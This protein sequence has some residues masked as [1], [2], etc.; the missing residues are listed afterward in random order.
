MRTPPLPS[1]PLHSELRRRIDL[2]GPLL[3]LLGAIG[4]A[5]VGVACGEAHSSLRPAT[6]AASSGAAQP[7][8]GDPAA[9]ANPA[10]SPA[11]ATPPSAPPG[12]SAP[13]LAAGWQVFGHEL[14]GKLFESNLK[15][16]GAPPRC[17]TFDY[18]PDGGIQS[19]WCHRPESLTLA[20][21]RA[22]SGVEVFVSGPHTSG[23]LN[24]HAANDFG[25]YNPAF[26]RWLVDKASPGPRGSATQ[27]L[28]QESYDTN[29]RPLAEAMWR[30]LRKAKGDPKCFE[31]ER[32]LYARAMARKALP[33]G[34]YERWYDFMSARFCS[35]G[36][37]SY[38]DPLTLMGPIGNVEGNVA[39]SAVGFWLRRSIDGTFDTFAE[40]LKK[41]IETYEPSLLTSP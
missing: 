14:D 31:R 22:L 6:P 40:G 33:A 16:W 34:Y 39:K 35:H 10:A 9:P 12:A 38:D 3:A 32:A 18:F 25:H 1:T 23:S 30:T 8:A 13:A 17:E 36:A 20:A 15:E 2:A 19:F 11:S 26:V 37:G 21:V 41:L 28:T 7:A 29:M 27:R 4:L 5:A 24:L